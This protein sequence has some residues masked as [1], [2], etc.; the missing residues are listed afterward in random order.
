MKPGVDN[1]GHPM[2]RTVG[3]VAGDE[4]CFDVF[5]DVFDP[6]IRQLHASFAEGSQHSTELDA[7]RISDLPLD[8]SGSSRVVSVQVHGSRSLSG[9]LRMPTAA[10]L[11]EL[12]E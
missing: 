9:G 3:L 8:A 12:C 11:D 4:S 10:S 7:S 1:K 6:V 5:K 2:V